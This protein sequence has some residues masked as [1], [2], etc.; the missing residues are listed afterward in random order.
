LKPKECTDEKINSYKLYEVQKY[1]VKTDH[2]PDIKIFVMNKVLY[3]SLSIQDSEWLRKFI[4]QVTEDAISARAAKDSELE[5]SF[6]RS[7]MQISQMPEDLKTALESCVQPVADL[8]KE[9]VD[10]SIVDDYTEACKRY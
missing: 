8:V 10:P 3:K 5:K 6:S 2:L 9:S 7:G 4:S 1:M